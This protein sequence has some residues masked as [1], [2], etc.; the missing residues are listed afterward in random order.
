MA[1]N[2][3]G[4]QIAYPTQYDPGQLVAIPRLLNRQQLGI[5]SALPFDGVDVWTAWECSWLDSRGKPVAV[6]LRLLIP[7]DSPNLVE[8]KSLKLYFNSLNQHRFPSEEA[9]VATIHS[10]VSAVI[11]SDFELALYT[12]DSFEL[13]AQ[14]VNGKCLDGLDLEVTAGEPDRALL[15]VAS[16]GLPVREVVYTNLF[17]SLCPITSQPD[18][19]T[20]VITYQ[21][22]PIE[23]PA[24]LHYLVSYR[25]HNDYHEHCVERM[26]TD[27][28][29]ACRPESLTIEASFLRRGGIDINPVRSSGEAGDYL[30]LPR[31]LRQ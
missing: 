18:W 19:A 25:N 27:I 3:L 22:R 8:S 17:R 14:P 28:K 5:N 23:H 4:K 12:L 7:C 24:L 26:F 30:D 9:A 6:I 21:G 1:A 13:H 11:G 16:E 20:V 15:A 29:A 31:Y 2:P 10:D